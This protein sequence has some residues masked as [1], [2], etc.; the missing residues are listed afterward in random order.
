[1]D[2]EFVLL[3][4]EKVRVE[5][6]TMNSVAGYCCTARPRIPTAY[7]AVPTRHLI[8]NVTASVDG[9]S[10]IQNAVDWDAPS[11]IKQLVR[12][13]DSEGTNPPKK[14]AHLQFGLLSAE[15]IE[16]I[17]EFQVTNRDLFSLPSRKP[18]AGGCLDPRLGVSDK[19]SVCSTCKRKLIE[20]AGHY[21]YIKLS[22]VYLYRVLALHYHVAVISTKLFAVPS[23]GPKIASIS[24]R[25]S[26]T[27]S[28]YPSVHLQDMLTRTTSSL[29]STSTPQAHAE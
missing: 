4:D 13:G 9:P 16:R 1:M 7:K 22:C 8:M 26:K 5:R 11:R 25:I 20:C 6:V 18:A 21:G 19:Y 2:L 17:A 12:E 10:A 27:H 28:T 14:I 15:E 24:H 23:H 29:R 3:I